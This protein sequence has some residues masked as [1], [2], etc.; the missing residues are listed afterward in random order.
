M[1]RNGTR[2]RAFLFAVGVGS[3]GCSEPSTPQDDVIASTG[4]VSGSTTALPTATTG[5]TTAPTTGT[6]SGTTASVPGPVV[7]GIIGDTQQTL[8][9]EIALGREVNDA[10][11][12]V[13][14]A[15][16]G[17]ETLD[18]VV[19]VGDLVGLGNSAEHWQQFDEFFAPVFATGAPVFPVL[20]N[21]EYCGSDIGCARR[22]IEHDISLDPVWER[23]PAMER[24][25]W[26]TQRI[27]DVALILLDTNLWE[28]GVDLDAAD[29]STTSTEFMR[30]V[31]WFHDRLDEF[32]ADP[33]ISAVVVAG[34][35]PMF[36][37]AD[38][39]YDDNPLV[40]VLE[41]EDLA[42]LRESFLSGMLSA[43]KVRLYVSGHA[44]GFEHFREGDVDFVVT[45]GG[46]GPR[47]DY[48][49][50]EDAEYE[51]LF[52]TSVEPRPFNYVL[53]H[54]EQGELSGVVMGV[55]KGSSTV[56]PLYEF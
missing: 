15:G 54:H 42:F 11:R 39:I 34:H 49:A 10:E 6:T 29:P 30:Q 12:D 40:P 9:G 53:L 21:H 2:V 56:T 18:A 37:N 51:D 52:A 14:L 17:S 13:I 8:Q 4:P 22:H 5:E 19:H 38:F 24:R 3:G 16:L 47:P 26:Y 36:S 23:F 1:E 27:G 28:Y 48:L 44:H 7:V 25:T 41:T 43:A 45:G 32:D 50:P 35:H 31:D 55:S 20:G 33:N 46:G